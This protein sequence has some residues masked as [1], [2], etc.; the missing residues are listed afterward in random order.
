MRSLRVLVLRLRS[1]LLWRRVD[2][3]LDT[4]FQFHIQKQ[5]EQYTRVG[6]PLDDARRAAIAD[7]GA[8]ERWKQ[9]CRDQRR[10]APVGAFATDIRFAIRS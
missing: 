2:A 6:V 9:D 3:E 5:I 4:E 7:M 8:V 10:V 1:L